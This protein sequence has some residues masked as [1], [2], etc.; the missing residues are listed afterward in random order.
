MNTLYFVIIF[1]FVVNILLIYLLVA[2]IKKEKEIRKEAIEKSRLVLEGKFKEQLAPF[3]PEF[4][5]NPTDARFIGSPVDF[6]VFDGAAESNIKKIVFL[7]V[8]SGK[9]KL[10][11]KE[12]QIKESIEK[13]RIEF[14]EMK[15][16]F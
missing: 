16:D 10:T 13:G 4:G 8:K 1:L 11:K 3:L 6:I 15:L 7:E 2:K 12:G 9:S 5:F 14:R